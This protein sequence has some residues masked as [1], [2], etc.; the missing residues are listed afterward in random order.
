M[1]FRARE[2]D[3]GLYQRSADAAP[4]RRRLHRNVL[5]LRL[6]LTAGRSGLDMRHDLIAVERD[7]DAAFVDVGVERARR[8]GLRPSGCR[9]RRCS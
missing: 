5:E 2:R 7:Q 6:V 8:V 9:D 3:R 1:P 4:L